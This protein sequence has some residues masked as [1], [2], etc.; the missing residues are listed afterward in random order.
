MSLNTMKINEIINYF[1]FLQWV[2]T[3]HMLNKRNDMEL[4]KLAFSMIDKLD[5][6][7]DF[8]DSL[9]HNTRYLTT[10][11]HAFFFINQFYQEN[12]DAIDKDSLDI[13]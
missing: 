8:I 12:R 3:D 10:L 1:H 6:N 7:D 11:N 13:G 9:T 2:S 5:I 4:I